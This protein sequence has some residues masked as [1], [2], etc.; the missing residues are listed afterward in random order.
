MSS[1][2][3]SIATSARPE[4]QQRPSSADE[5]VLF[6]AR[7]ATVRGTMHASG[8]VATHAVYR[9]R[10]AV[11]RRSVRCQCRGRPVLGT[12]GLVRGTPIGHVGG[13]PSGGRSVIHLWCGAKRPRFSSSSDESV[14][15]LGQVVTGTGKFNPRCV[16]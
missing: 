6:V 16:L 2:S 8:M 12:W 14:L 7:V 13:R 4:N 3:S 5:D 9:V 11:P 1:T 10:G 15:C